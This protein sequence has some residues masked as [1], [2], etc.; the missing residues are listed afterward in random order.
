MNFFE[1]ELINKPRH[2]P[3]PVATQ[4]STSN[5]TQDPTNA[6]SFMG[7]SDVPLSVLPN[8]NGWFSFLN[9]NNKIL[10]WT[11]AIIGIFVFLVWFSNS[12]GGNTRTKNKN[13]DKNKEND[14]SEDAY[15]S[16][17]S[18]DDSHSLSDST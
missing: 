17:F 15:L 8:S 13:N 12:Y 16:D 7:L 1:N 4:T 6:K 3:P 2:S 10:I 5:I 9:G 18:D 11:A 14:D